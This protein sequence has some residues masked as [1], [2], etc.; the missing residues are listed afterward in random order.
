MVKHVNVCAYICIHVRIH[1]CVYRYIQTYIYTYVVCV[2]GLKDW[3]G[4]WSLRISSQE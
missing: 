2:E 4:N 1:M 3:F